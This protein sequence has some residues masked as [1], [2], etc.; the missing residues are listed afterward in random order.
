MLKMLTRPKATLVL[1][2]GTK[3]VSKSFGAT[4]TVYGE[5]VFNTAMVGYQEIITDPSYANQI[6]IMTYPEIG[7]YGINEDDFECKTPFT[8]GMVVKNH[9]PIYSH[10]K[11]KKSLGEYFKE[12]GILGIENIDTRSLTKK[13]REHGTMACMLTTE[14][15]TEDKIETL[16]NYKAD[17]DIVLKVSRKEPE[18]FSETGE[19][20]VALIDYGCKR[21]IMK[22]LAQRGCAITIY[23]A[24]TKAD[25]ILK[26]NFDLVFLSN[27]PGD[28]MDC[29][30]QV[31]NVKNLIGKIPIYGICLGYQI[32]AI[33]LGA[34]TYKLKYGHRGANHPVMYLGSKKVII[35]SQNHG[36]AVDESTLSDKM[37]MTHIN[38][39]DKTLEGFK[40]E[41]LKIFAVQFHPE[42]APGPLDA[43][44]IFDEWI[45][46][47]KKDIK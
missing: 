7:N 5:I 47:M 41:S 20:K 1:E 11:A 14:E 6:I 9:N 10:Y 36:Y 8:K 24:S 27:G 25:T 30:E 34:T 18:V 33:A 2:D 16:K 46:Q 15:I 19:I 45:E 28:P 26:E 35:T 32:L 38:L 12:H 44:S 21:G 29:K 40:S 43:E 3:Y 17:R 23:P 4:G 13:I 42:H 39:N 22:S 37:E 31:E